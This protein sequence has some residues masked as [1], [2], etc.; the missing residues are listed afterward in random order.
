MKTPGWYREAV[1]AH[2]ERVAAG[3]EEPGDAAEKLAALLKEH[4]EFLEDIAARDIT[5]WTDKHARPGFLQSALFPAIPS[6]LAVAV[7]QK[8]RVADM[9]GDDLDKARRMLLTRTRNAEGAARRQRKA[10]LRFYG[11]IRPLLDEDPGMTVAEAIS[12]LHGRR[13]EKA[14]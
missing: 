9:T 10:F 13:K 11:E 2:G 7:G 5:R 1:A 3:A 8:A 14:A 4:P 12:E 6:V